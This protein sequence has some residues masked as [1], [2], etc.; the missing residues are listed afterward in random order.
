MDRKTML[1]E[2]RKTGKLRGGST[3]RSLARTLYKNAPKKPVGAGVGTSSSALTDEVGL[4]EGF[5]KTLFTWDR[6][7]E[8][9]LL[10]LYIN[11]ADPLG[12]CIAGLRDGDWIQVTSAAGIAYFAQ[13][14]GNPLAAGIVGVIAKGAE[15]G[16]TLSG[17][18]AF[19]PLVAAAEA[20]AQDQFKATGEKK[21]ARDA[22]GE[23]PSSG[24]KARAEG[25]V[26]VS[27]PAAGSPSFSGDSDHK[28]RWIKVPGTRIDA[29]RPDHVKD[30]FFPMKGSPAHNGRKLLM[31]GDLYITPWDWNFD[32]NAG[33][34][35]VILRIWK[36]TAPAIGNS[37]I[38]E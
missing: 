9:I 18:A 17:N 22:F 29:N 32:D 13:D 14:T 19:V 5:V 8:E 2:I 37:E 1:A 21:K 25:G 3:Y 30:A 20:F 16:L 6:A 7:D 34:Y 10:A 28:S 33:Y 11:P 23:E 12:V 38:V 35:R 27:L 36:S 15:V 26:L 4:P 24:L 31:G